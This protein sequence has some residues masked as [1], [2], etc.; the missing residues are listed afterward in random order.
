MKIKAAMIVLGLMLAACGAETP[1]E[2]PAAAATE[3]PESLA[4]PMTDAMDEAR[5]VEDQV[6]EQKEEVEAA[7][8]EAEETAEDE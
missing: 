4:E 7:L 5:A 1:S 3:D 2:E 6:M 8:E